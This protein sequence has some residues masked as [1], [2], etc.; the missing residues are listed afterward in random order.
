MLGDTMLVDALIDW[1]LHRGLARGLAEPLAALLGVVALA[2]AAW[3]ASVIAKR[4]IL[5][6][7]LPLIERSSARWDDVLL[8]S[9]IFSRLSYLAPALVGE[10][11]GQGVLLRAGTAAARLRV[12]LDV[13]VVVVALLVVDA[14]FDAGVELYNQGA[15][16]RR[17]PLRG[18]AQGAKLASFLFGA[19]LITSLLLGQSPVYLLSGLGALTAVL[20]LVFKDA[21]LGLVAGVQI[22]VN[23]MV[24][25]GDWIEM[26]KYGADGD[27]IDVG[28]TTVK[29]QN[30]D[31]TITTV[32]TYALISDPVKNWRGMQESGGR[33][34]KRAI[35]LD[36]ESFRFLDEPLLERLMRFR[37]LRPYLEQKQRDI[38]EW[39]R[40]HAEDLSVVVNGRRLTNIGCFRAY[41][42]AYLRA[43]PQ[44]HQG[45]TLLVRQLQPSDK[46]LPL[47]IY[48]FTA[49]TRWDVYESVQ[50]D[51][52]DHLL[53]VVTQFELRVFQ[54]PSGHDVRRLSP[55][56]EAEAAASSVREVRQQT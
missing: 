47:E 9:G 32:P 17:V 36:V 53:T 51:I 54:S 8:K 49:D 44:V 46:G 24:Q 10:W 25:I 31:K 26:S 2:A 13:Y 39:N 28:L 12:V 45:M 50:A 48:A 34:I 42:D 29:V 11:L 56:I 3:L 4:I 52:F 20:L 16:S 18:F 7:V 14:L 21:L 1:M 33:R 40:T 38:A 37:R 55:A 19:V 23:R 6:L 35:F 30:W 5:K 27:V 22:S 43:H 41:A 15:T